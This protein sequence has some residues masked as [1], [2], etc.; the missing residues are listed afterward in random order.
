MDT[1]EALYSATRAGRL[2]AV[3]GI[4][5]RRAATIRATLPGTLERKRR[6]LQTA[7][8]T[9]EGPEP[10][11]AM[12]LAKDREYRMAAETGKLR[13]TAPKRLNP[14]GLD[15]LTVLHTQ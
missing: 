14:D 11:A 13:K 7:P 1:L 12:L 4:C 10:L 3:D 6:L 2:E 5:P 15:S 8:P 9:L